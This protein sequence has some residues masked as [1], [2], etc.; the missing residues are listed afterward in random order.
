MTAL[1][2][3]AAS[4]R[5]LLRDRVGL[6]FMVLLPIVLILVIGATVRGQSEFRV[7]V[8]DGDGPLA[9]RLVTELD[10]SSSVDARPYDDEQA[11]RDALRRG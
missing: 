3:A 7:G 5:R 8:A 11:A 6:F 2:I 1:T 9:V 4:L 10:G